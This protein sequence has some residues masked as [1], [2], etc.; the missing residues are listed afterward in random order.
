MTGIFVFLLGFFS[1]TLRCDYCVMRALETPRLDVKDH[2]TDVMPASRTSPLTNFVPRKLW[3]F[4]DHGNPSIPALQHCMDSWRSRNPD[5]EF[6][7]VTTKTIGKFLDS[8]VESLVSL[9]SLHVQSL[10]DVVRV[11]LLAKYGGVYADMDVY[12]LLPLNEWVDDLVFPSGF[13]V[14]SLQGG[15]RFI[16]SWFMASQRGNP[17]MIAWRQRMIDHIQRHHKF[18][19]SLQLHYEFTKLVSLGEFKQAWSKTPKIIAAYANEACCT[20]VLGAVNNVSRYSVQQT[21]G[22]F[23]ELNADAKAMIDSGKVPL[24]KGT[25]KGNAGWP[26]TGSY[27]KIVPSLVDYLNNRFPVVISATRDKDKSSTQRNVTN[28]ER[29]LQ[30]S[31]LVINLGLP[32]SGTT[33]LHG[34]LGCGGIRSS[35]WQCGEM[36]CGSCIA[37]NIRKKKA[38]F[39]GC[40]SYK[41]WAQMDIMEPNNR[42]CLLPQ[43]HHAQTILSYYP[44][45]LFVLP[46]RDPIAWSDSVHRWYGRMDQRLTECVSRHWKSIQSQD[47]HIDVVANITKKSFS[48]INSAELVEFYEAHVRSVKM[49]KVLNP[50][51]RL[52]Q[53]NISDPQKLFEALPNIPK[54]CYKHKNHN[55]KNPGSRITQDSS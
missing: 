13:F 49:L 21:G 38:P 15:D 28:H 42:G 31:E 5:W 44:D 46:L 14:F 48:G 2:G 23:Q 40:G 50:T 33:T 45:A 41:G 10:S 9:R 11:S 47:K 26:R 19:D 36:P 29:P 55:T 7:L 34:F 52:I 53:Y 37:K 12:N 30:S 54:H 16:A 17:V 35:H 24:I 32:K 18:V 39:T 8:D 43:T 22:Y 4:W 1:K 20:A 3:M 27:N 25:Y 6:Y 51:L